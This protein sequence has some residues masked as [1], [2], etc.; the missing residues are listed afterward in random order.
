VSA[1]SLTD[2]LAAVAHGEWA[3]AASL[4]EQ[5]AADDPHRRLARA[6]ATYLGDLPAPGVYDEPAAFEAFIDNGGNVELY[7]RTIERLA[8]VHAGVRPDAVLDIGCGD[9]RVTAQVLHHTTRRVDL[10][11]PSAELLASATAALRAARS[12]VDVG[13]HQSDARTFLAALDHSVRWDVVQST[14]AMHATQPADRAEILRQLAARTDRLLVVEFD[15]PVFVDRSPAHLAY[16]VERYERGVREY[17][18][19][20]EVVAQFLMPVLVGQLDPARPRYTFEHPIDEWRALLHD[21]GFATTATPV[22]PY[23]WADAV[24]IDAVPRRSR[25]PAPEFRVP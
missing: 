15:V 4:A 9:G 19:H 8:A 3:Q 22:A 16:L 1:A 6:L 14:F 7:R 10:V 5:V 2:A 20:P 11:E 24:L 17:D 12:G 18:D 23:W 13:A 21:A 25:E